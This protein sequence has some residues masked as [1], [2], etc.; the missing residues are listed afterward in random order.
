M[1]FAYLIVV[2]LFCQGLYIILTKSNL[3]KMIM[4]FSI[5]ESALIM[6]LVLIGYREGGTVP[7]IYRD[8]STV[9]DPIPQALAL[10]AIVIGASIT[11]VMLAF[12]IKI[13]KKYGTIDLN[14]IKELRNQ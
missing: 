6:L 1:R 2:I 8:F 9:V 4:G 5:A 7:I 3:I 13:H 14:E 11:A 10:T 12:T